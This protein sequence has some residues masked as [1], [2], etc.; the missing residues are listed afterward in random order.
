VRRLEITVKDLTIE[1]EK[2]WQTFVYESNNGT[3][4]HLLEWRDILKKE[5]QF[6]PEYLLAR[7]SD[8]KICGV[9]PLF[10]VKNFRGARLESLPFSIYGGPIATTTDAFSMLIKAAIEKSIEMKSKYLVLKMQHDLQKNVIFENNLIEDKYYIRSVLELSENQDETWA[11]LSRDKKR[12]VKNARK[13]NVTVRIAENLDDVKSFYELELLTRKKHGLPT[14]SLRYFYDIW[15]TL[16]AKNLV[17]ILLAEHNEKA[18][19]G[20]MLFTFKDTILY[21]IGASDMRYLKYRPNNL[22]LWEGIEW[23]C[24]NGYRYF[25]FGGTPSDHLSLLDFKKRWGAINN[26]YPYYYFPQKYSIKSDTAAQNNNGIVQ[27]AGTYL[28]KKMPICISKIVGP[29]LIKYFG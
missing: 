12:Q 1:D 13:M 15:R 11:K 19:A 2:E 23:G 29:P 24:R 22:V 4:Y 17:R 25:D 26:F 10:Y 16:E 9:L 21:A 7:D 8:A 28:F 18:I 3:V 14:P 5:Y 20:T 6:K 27:R